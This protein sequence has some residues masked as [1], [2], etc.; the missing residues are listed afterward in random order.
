MKQKILFILYKDGVYYRD[1]EL[2]FYPLTLAQQDTVDLRVLITSVDAVFNEEP[3][4]RN[5]PITITFHDD[6]IKLNKLAE[7]AI[8]SIGDESWGRREIKMKL[9]EEIGVPIVTVKRY[10]KESV[11]KGFIPLKWDIGSYP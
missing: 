8:T 6:F 10:Y 4:K 11:E 1:R 9:V 3:R 2:L 7:V 5:Q